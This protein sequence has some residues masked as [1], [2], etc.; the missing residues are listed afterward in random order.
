V[1]YGAV[2]Q[3][4]DVYVE[5]Q[6]YLRAANDRRHI[7]VA[8]L[9]AVQKGLHLVALYRKALGQSAPLTLR[10]RCDNQ[11]A[12]TWLTRAAQR[13]WTTVKGLSAKVV[14]KTIMTI[15]DDC[16]S[17][18]VRLEVDFI[19]SAENPADPLSRVPDFLRP[20]PE[21]FDPAPVGDVLVNAILAPGEPLEFDAY[22]R[23]VLDS[24]TL[25][26]FMTAVHEHEGANALYQRLH[27]IVAN[28]DL[29]R[30]CQEFVRSCAICAMSKVTHHSPV[31]RG[32][33]HLPE[34]MEPFAHVHLD[35]AGPYGHAEGLDQFY[36]L[37]LIDRYSRFVLTKC[38]CATPNGSD[39]VSLLRTTFDRFHVCVD[40]VHTDNGSQFVCAEFARTLTDLGAVSRTTPVH[41]SWAN[42]R[43]ER[44]HRVL[45]ERLRAALGAADELI[46]FRQ[47]D[48]VV[49]KATLLHNTAR[50][51]RTGQSPHDM[52]FSFPAW[53]YPQW[54]HLRPPTD[55]TAPVPDTPSPADHPLVGRRLPAVGEIWLYRAP[56]RKKIQW[57]YTPCRITRRV[58]TQTYMVKLQ[59]NKIRKVHLRCLKFLSPE[60]ATKL[61]PKLTLP[62]DDRPVRDLRRRGGHVES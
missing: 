26:R 11:S 17:L 46:S 37:S 49:A 3:I 23:V 32:D 1:A 61:P 31:Q 42:G 35:I 5:D 27:P 59:S 9:I 18:G 60:A 13:H 21:P 40:V 36:V 25:L 34:V 52:L 53:I 16:Q 15:V 45:N 28:P 33:A 57:P 22:H 24:P 19:P 30:Q 43:V 12:V 48:S 29:R 41:S 10:L 14:E 4:G 8:E 6:T 62:L 58:S 54:K 2:L 39:A 55:T 7:N 20:P 56:A 50:H 44:W 51:S 47:F 38:T